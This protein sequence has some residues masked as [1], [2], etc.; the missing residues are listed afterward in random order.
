MLAA[1]TTR[2][3]DCR[4]LQCLRRL[5]PRLV[6]PF[7]AG[8]A[9]APA[10]RGSWT[11]RATACSWHTTPSSGAG[12]SPVVTATETPIPRAV[13]LREAREKSGLDVRALDDAIFDIDVHGSPPR[14]EEPAHLHFDVRF[15]IQAE[16]DRFRV[17][18]ESPALAWAPA[19]GLNALTDEESVL[20]VARK[21]VVRRR[22]AEH[23][24]PSPS[25]GALKS[26]LR[27]VHDRHWPDTPP[28]TAQLPGRAHGPSGA[29]TEHR[30]AL[31]RRREGLET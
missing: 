16:H 23:L 4:T 9:T 17:S 19:V 15:L 22:R 8:S 2:V 30:D 14:G 26:A 6:P 11:G 1:I 13:A 10:R 5:A 18:D 24:N 20:R 29:E 31:K 3:G 25:P 21:W 28:L 27:G 12:C 7:P